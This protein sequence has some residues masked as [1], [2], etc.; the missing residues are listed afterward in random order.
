MWPDGARDEGAWKSGKAQGIGKFV[1]VDSEM[2]HGEGFNDQ[3]YGFGVYSHSD[4]G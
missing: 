2:Y 1:H 3:A 4:G